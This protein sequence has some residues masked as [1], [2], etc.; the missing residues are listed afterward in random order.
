MGLYK[1]YSETPQD[2]SR[3]IQVIGAGYSRTGTVSFSLALERLLNGPVCHSGATTL[4][5]EEGTSDFSNLC[6]TSLQIICFQ[7]YKTLYLIEV[8]LLIF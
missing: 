4:L 6:P 3:S 2:L 7:I 1:K 8:T 5:R